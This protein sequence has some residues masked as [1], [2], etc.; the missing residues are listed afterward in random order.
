MSGKRS[1]ISLKRSVLVKDWD[2]NK[3]RAKGNSIKI[4]SLNTYLD[5]VFG[6]LLN[7]QKELLYEDAIISSDS[8]KARYLGED[9]TSKTLRDLVGYHHDKIEIVLKLGTMKNYYST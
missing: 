4:R 2:S 9:E 3:S 6:K 1:E 5:E 8:I 7:C